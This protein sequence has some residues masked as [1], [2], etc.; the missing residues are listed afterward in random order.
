MSRRLFL[1]GCKLIQPI[2]AERPVFSPHL[3]ISALER[4]KAARRHECSAQ[5][6]AGLY[7]RVYRAD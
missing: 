1:A 2:L 7:E 6:P 5:R 4:A 3:A